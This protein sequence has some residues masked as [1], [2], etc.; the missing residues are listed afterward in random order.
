MQEGKSVPELLL[1]FILK[2]CEVI[3]I[4]LCL[5]SKHFFPYLHPLGLNN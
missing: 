4:L 2:V 3:K 1:L 5:F